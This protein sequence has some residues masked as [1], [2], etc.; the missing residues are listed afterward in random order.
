M[1]QWRLA[2]WSESTIGNLSDTSCE[3]MEYEALRLL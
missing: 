2:P 1:N 3:P